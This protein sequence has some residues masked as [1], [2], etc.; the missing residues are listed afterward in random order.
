MARI[1]ALY[2]AAAQRGASPREYASVLEHLDFVVELAGT[3]SLPA[4]E[5]IKS[6]RAAL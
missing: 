2:Q 6:V 4:A 5:A 3:A 1:V